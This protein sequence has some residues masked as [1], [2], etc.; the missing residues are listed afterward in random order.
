[1]NPSMSLSVGGSVDFDVRPVWWAVWFSEWTLAHTKLG[2][3]PLSIYHMIFMITSTSPYDMIQ[4]CAL[5]HG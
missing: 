2:P 4:R 1:M 5:K 3:S